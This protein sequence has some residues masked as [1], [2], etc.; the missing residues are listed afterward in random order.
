[1]N[2]SLN[3]SVYNQNEHSVNFGKS[4][5]NN[6]KG[7]KHH[8]DTNS[9]KVDK[10][11]YNVPTQSLW[12]KAK[13]KARQIAVGTATGAQVAN[14]AAGVAASQLVPLAAV[15][16]MLQSCVDVDQDVVVDMA[17]VLD[18]LDQLMK[19]IGENNK[20]LLAELQALRD[21][22]N[23]GFVESNQLAAKILQAL[24]NANLQYAEIIEIINKY[25]SNGE[26]M[27]DKILSE[28]KN[29]T[30]A[31]SKLD[32]LKDAIVEMDKN[33]QEAN[34]KIVDKINE[35]IK[36]YQK[37]NMTMQELMSKVIGL[38]GTSNSLSQSILDKVTELYEKYENGGLTESDL[39]QEII[40]QLGGINDKLDKIYEQMLVDSENFNNYVESN[41]SN[42]EKLFGNMDNLFNGLGNIE[43][44]LDVIKTNGDL[45]NDYLKKISSSVDAANKSLTEIKNEIG[46]TNVSIGDLLNYMKENGQK[47]YEP[48]LREMLEKL[49][50]LDEINNKQFTIEDLQNA[51][52][53]FKT[54]LST[55]NELIQTAIG[56]LEKIASS[57]GSTDLSQV[58]QLLSQI[59]SA[60]TSG[61]SDVQGLLNKLVAEAEKIAA[62]IGDIN[63]KLDEIA[64][65]IDKQTAAIE[66]A[67][68]NAASYAELILA[69]LQR[70]NKDIADI[71]NYGDKLSTFL[72]KQEAAQAE[73]VGLLKEILAQQGGNSSYQELLDAVKEGNGNTQRI[74]ELLEDLNIKSGDW[75]TNNTLNQALSANK[76]NLTTTNEL[77]Q[78]AIGLLESIASNNPSGGGNINT[79][80]MESLLGQIL[81]KLT[82]NQT[83]TSSQLN[84][85]KAE[86]QNV[87]N[88]IKNAGGTTAMSRK[89]KAAHETLQN[90]IAYSQMAKAE[91]ARSYDNDTFYW[92]S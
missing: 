76:T 40:N 26:V 7:H 43:A 44:K 31:L 27:L 9:A 21:Q 1:M 37:G 30:Q 82:N 2:I 39:L 29:I 50:L 18:K 49:G 6:K 85:L 63:D 87:Q 12:E 67:K 65:K 46:K 36:E 41:Q 17:P 47:D 24:D 16:A 74:K 55:T 15:V 80:Q 79:T 3:E 83:A 69:E 92:R 88:A 68:D 89:Q 90:Y 77:I 5:K 64:G 72:T 19:L 86:I 48:I 78:T 4:K 54:D 73:A 23:A 51:L 10:S 38:L 35:Q 13:S 14:P 28:L 59:Y 66:S 25:G 8:A 45:S 33:N 58:N 84:E 42:W 61:D 70:G 60:I 52:K 91:N 34:Q 11:I 22:V 56:L 53:G 75:V 71:K 32:E 57:D 62:G 81:T 20:A